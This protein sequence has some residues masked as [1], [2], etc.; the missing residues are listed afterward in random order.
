[1]IALLIEPL[2]A[3]RRSLRLAMV[4]AACAALAGVL[5]LAVSGW[6]LSQTERRAA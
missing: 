4:C 2:R 5:L 6:F 3:Q 1:M